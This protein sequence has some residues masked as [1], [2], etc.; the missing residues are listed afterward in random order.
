MND[1]GLDDCP[2]E[3]LLPVVKFAVTG[4]GGC[5]KEDL[6]GGQVAEF[7]FDVLLNGREVLAK[8]EFYSYQLSGDGDGGNF[9]LQQRRRLPMTRVEILLLAAL[10]FSI[11]NSNKMTRQILGMIRLMWVLP[12]GLGASW[13]KSGR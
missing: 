7:G 3:E 1:G 13:V 2:P 8:E 5:I 10:K 12:F 9:G 4:N 11:R 6:T